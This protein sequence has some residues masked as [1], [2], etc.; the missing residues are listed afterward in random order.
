[1]FVSLIRFFVCPETSFDN[2]NA[3]SGRWMVV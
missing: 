1:L 3:Q 2:E